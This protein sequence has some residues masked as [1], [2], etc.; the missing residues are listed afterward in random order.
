M[1][2]VDDLPI[3]NEAKQILLQE[4]ISKLYPP[5]EKAIRA[6]ALE[7]QNIVLSSP[8][9][10]GKTLIAILAS[11]RHFLDK[12]GKILYLTPLRALAT[13]KFEDFK[14]FEK[15]GL[16]IALSIGDYDSSD[17]WLANYNVIITTNEK[18]DS[19]LRH[20]AEWLSDIS[21]IIIDEIHLIGSNKRGPTL[22]MLIANLKGFL[23]RKA[24]IIALSATIKNI[25]EISEWLNAK[26]LVSSWRPVK[27]TE[28]VYYDGEIFF[29]D[30]RTRKINN[31]ADPVTDLTFD[32]LVDNGQVLI[33]TSTRRNAVA[34]AKKL[35]FNLGKILARKKIINK[36]STTKVAKNILSTEDNQIT[37]KLSEIVVNGVAFHHAGLSYNIR[38]I[39]ED[40]F[41]NN[42]IKII[43]ATPTLAAGVNLPSRR[44]IISDYRRY[45][46]ELGYYE[47]IPVMEYKQMAGR[48]G[49]PKYDKYGESILIAKTY[50]ELD[51]LMEEY[52]KAE[53]ERIYSKLSSEPVLRSHILAII[54]NGFANT[55]EGIFNILDSTLYAIQFNVSSLT[56]SVKSILYFLNNSGM[57][58]LNDK[59]I[60]SPLGK[61]VTE[62]YIDPLTASHILEGLEKNKHE[63]LGYLHMIS[64]TPD[65]PKLYLRKKEKEKYEEILEEIQQSLLFEPPVDPY[66]Y[67]YF[68]AEVKTAL[69]IFDW[70]E[71]KPENY[72]IE[73][74]DVGP[75][76]I[77][78]ITR[79]AEWLL[80]SSYELAK[81]KGFV[82]HL[83]HLHILRERVKY[84]VKTELLELARI[85]M[86]G[87]VRAR[88]LFNHGYRTIQDL[89]KADIKDL[90]KIP[91]IGKRIA[92]YLKDIVEKGNYTE[93]LED[94]SID[95]K[96][97]KEERYETL[98]TYLDL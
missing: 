92:R 61:R 71:E 15:M 89:A 7:Y 86:I 74:Y 42:V 17:P 93:I 56:L 6:G 50:D 30:G 55:I 26:P 62:L 43:V 22:E 67:E 64:S 45:N 83:K 28:G 97:E 72:I 18:A 63:I 37:Q 76:D 38:K 75:G 54:S 10:S 29:E 82:K 14:K 13:E 51:L 35:S 39:I 2:K 31:L 53:P 8:T 40:N 46:V 68:L 70:I 16:K 96:T 58:H 85:K 19:L 66:D 52:I 36:K 98:D 81:I 21:L 3:P 73:K 77:Y 27:L 20:K 78:N 79:N 65:M 94:F 69:L 84:G 4:G 5:Q 49:R 24:Q 60:P 88:I 59:I 44:V 33:F 25:K 32:G 12:K 34:L 47:K 48:A 80:Y 90:A 23:E 95:E 9:A 91:T 57:L 41:K 87:R 1:I 11:L